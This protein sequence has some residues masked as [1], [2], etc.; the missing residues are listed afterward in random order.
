MSVRGGDLGYTGIDLNLTEN[1]LEYE[2]QEQE[3]I[4][5]QDVLISSHPGLAVLPAS[6]ILHTVR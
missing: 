4:V 6:H 3:N 1:G 5:S 2:K